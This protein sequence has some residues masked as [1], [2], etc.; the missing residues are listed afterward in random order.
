MTKYILAVFILATSVLSAQ[1]EKKSDIENQ[2]AGNAISVTI[3]GA[4]LVN[5]SFSASPM[6]RVDQFITRLYSSYEYIILQKTENSEEAKVTLAY[7]KRGIKL[8]R[9]NGEILN[10]DLD[11]FRLTG[12]FSY[13]P[14]I[15]NDDVL[16]F[17]ELD[18]EKNFIAVHGGVNNP[19]TFQFVEG[20]R[21]SDALLFARGIRDKERVEEIV[22]SRLSYDGRSEERILVKEGEDPQLQKGDR[23]IVHEDESLKRDYVAYVSGEVGIPGRVAITKNTT[24]LYEVIERA[25]GF[26]ETADLERAELIR[27]TNIFKSS[28]F[29]EEY[30]ALMMNRMSNL[31]PADSASFMVDNKL[32]FFRGNGV[33]DFNRL[34]DTSSSVSKF[35]VRDGDYIY[36]P[37]KV[38]MIYVYGQVNNPGYIEY[39]KGK[40]ID[41]YLAKAGGISKETAKDELYL[42]KGKTRSWI[43]IED[44]NNVVIQSGDFIWV[45]K[46]TPK[47]F[48]Y[49]LQRIGSIASIVGTIATVTVLL[50]QIIK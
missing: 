44:G 12:D 19:V 10:I 32:R 39:I 40:D 17:P 38:N 43:K 15:K 14:F 34:K 36:V 23:I 37:E 47:T 45:P 31:Q 9:F 4:F 25:G 18:L 3:G 41:Y 29:T 2:I 30:E 8:K 6:E 35:I 21:V 49:Y 16:I 42:I 20:D 22:I 28:V 50:I 24:T 26:K 5:G 11:K 1:F 33:L 48:N 46:E 7:A 27:G 13:N